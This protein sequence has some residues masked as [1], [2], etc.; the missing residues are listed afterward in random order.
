MAKTKV[1]AVANQE[2]G[3]GKSVSFS[4][5]FWTVVVAID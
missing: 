5:I 3:V 1:I 2:G 4:D